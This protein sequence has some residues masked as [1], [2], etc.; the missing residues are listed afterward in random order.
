MRKGI[1]SWQLSLAVILASAG[2][3]FGSFACGSSPDPM[4]PS[5]TETSQVEGN[6]ETLRVV[7]VENLEY[8]RDNHIHFDDENAV[9]NST[10]SFYEKKFGED[11]SAY[12]SIAAAAIE[13]N[14][15]SRMLQDHSKYS[16]NLQAIVQRVN[17]ARN[18]APDL[19]HFLNQLQD[20]QKTVLSSSWTN[21]DKTSSISYLILLEETMRYLGQDQSQELLSSQFTTE[22]FSFWRCAAGVVGGAI[23]GGLTGAAA[24]SVIPAIGTTAGGVW[25]AIGGGLTG[26]AAAC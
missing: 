4:G 6:A 15:S 25:G 21:P 14:E 1:R 11:S 17:D 8:L 20:L 7:Y 13:F 19:E 12:R 26:A 2:I 22:A 5:D 23:L 18:Q 9:L 24:G 10:L 3:I 16:K